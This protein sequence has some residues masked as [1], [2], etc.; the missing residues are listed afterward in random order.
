M[1]HQ[2]INCSATYDDTSNVI[3]K[4]CQ[5]CKGKLFLY[6]RSTKKEEI[7]EEVQ[8]TQKNKEAILSEIEESLGTREPQQP[9]FLKV[10]NV[11]VIAPGKYE[12]DINQLLKKDKPLVYKVGEGTFVIDLEYLQNIK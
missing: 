1:P 8:L 3:L 5:H 11:R 12:I 2:C 6:I 10:E 4:G 9:V 7:E